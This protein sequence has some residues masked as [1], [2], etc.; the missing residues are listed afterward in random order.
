VGVEHDDDDKTVVVVIVSVVDV[1][2]G[3]WGVPV[4]AEG[5]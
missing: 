1:M 4:R 2:T 5:R 3:V